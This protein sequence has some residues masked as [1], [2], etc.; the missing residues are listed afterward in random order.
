MAGLVQSQAALPACCPELQSLGQVI[1]TEEEGR[2]RLERGGVKVGVRGREAR[3]GR[4]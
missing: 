3:V 1:P 2:D 4:E